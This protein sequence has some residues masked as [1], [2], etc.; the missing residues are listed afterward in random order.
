MYEQ[1]VST[2]V[3]KKREKVEAVCSSV[4]L[5]IVYLEVGIF[6]YLEIFKR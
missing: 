6:L 2:L 4:D 1:V 3:K 5:Q